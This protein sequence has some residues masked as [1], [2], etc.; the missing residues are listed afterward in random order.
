MKHY[1]YI[2]L[3]TS[4]TALS[5]NYT[6]MPLD[7]GSY[8]TDFYSDWQ[9]CSNSQY[10]IIGDTT[11]G[12][13]T[14]QKLNKISL[15][16]NSTGSPCNSTTPIHTN[17][18]TIAYLRNDT[19][20]KKVWMYDRMS[21]FSRE[22]LLY[23]FDLIIGDTINPNVYGISQGYHT[24]GSYPIFVIDSIDSLN[25]AGII[26]KRYISLAPLNTT[27]FNIELIEGIGSTTGFISDYEC[28]LS[29]ASEL[30]CSRKNNLIRYVN[31]NSLNYTISCNII[32]G[33]SEPQKDLLKDLIIYPNP[34]HDACNISA[35]IPISIVSVYSVHG[36]LI[37]QFYPETM[38]LYCPIP[39][40]IGIY[41][42]NIQLENGQTFSKRIIK[43]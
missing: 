7:S 26:Y 4:S 31:P 23:D 32:T 39:S 30:T 13:L 41:F 27:C 20:N 25:I 21:G 34:A 36:K 2:L 5:Q 1:L 42:I 28:S 11:I 14:Y 18:G 43:Q 29:S 37:S 9:A 17:F 16:Y 38:E 33:Y 19:V 35:K 24:G 40:E 6:P 3:F 15:K 8:W 12:L 22:L 10:S